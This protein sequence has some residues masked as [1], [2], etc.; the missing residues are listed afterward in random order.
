MLAS[1]ITSFLVLTTTLHS[2]TCYSQSN[3]VAKGTWFQEITDKSDVFQDLN[4]PVAT[5]FGTPLHKCN[6]KEQCNF[7]LQDLTSGKYIEFNNESDLP[8][9][10]ARYL[11]WK[12]M[13]QSKMMLALDR[14]VDNVFLY[15]IKNLQDKLPITL[16]TNYSTKHHK[17]DGER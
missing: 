8:K 17:D 12:K 4:T 15:S 13:P 3:G 2:A 11:I 6:K 5:P 7:L 14:P 9:D 16:P 1:S 10:R